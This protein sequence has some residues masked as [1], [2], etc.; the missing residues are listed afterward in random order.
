MRRLLAGKVL[1][2]H[3]ENCIH[4]IVQEYPVIQNDRI[5]TGILRCGDAFR[6]HSGRIILASPRRIDCPTCLTRRPPIH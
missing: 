5:H 2:V 3:F 1:A 6:A 4:E